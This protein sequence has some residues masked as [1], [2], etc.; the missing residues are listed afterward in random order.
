M[1][2]SKTAQNDMRNFQKRTKFHEE[3]PKVHKIPRGSLVGFCAHLEVPHGILCIF[4]SS[5]YH[6]VRLWKFLMGFY[7]VLEFPHGKAYTC[8]FHPFTFSLQNTCFYDMRNFQK[9]TKSHEELPNVHKIPRGS[10]KNAQNPMIDF[11]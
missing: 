9:C 7:A 6:F 3:L 11:E 10:S 1:K 2:N 8:P 5:S 4:G